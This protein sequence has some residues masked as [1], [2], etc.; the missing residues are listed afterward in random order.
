M[1]GIDQ[2][3]SSGEYLFFFLLQWQWHRHGSEVLENTLLILRGRAIPPSSVGFASGHREVLS[4]S[5]DAVGIFQYLLAMPVP[6]SQYQGGYV[7]PIPHGLWNDVVTWGGV[8]LTRSSFEPYNVV[9]SHANTQN[10]FPHN[11]FDIQ[12]SF[13]TTISTVKEVW[14]SISVC[15]SRSM[16]A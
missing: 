5:Q 15:Q 10:L 7:N 8:F 1:S 14:L 13:D 6:L 12:T 11:F 16:Y 4:T 3:Q 9:K 2:Y